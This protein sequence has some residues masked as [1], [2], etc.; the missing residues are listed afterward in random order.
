MRSR[1]MRGAALPLAVATAFVMTGCSKADGGGGDASG[2][3]EGVEAGA[4]MEEY[5]AAFADV[6]PIEL[7]FQVASPNPEAYSALRDQQFAESLEEWSDGKISVNIHYSGAIAA[8]TEVP[9]A[10]VDGRLDLA[11]YYTTYEPQEMP[12]FV[13]MT[14][15]AVQVPST[16]LVGEIVMHAAL[17]EVGFN[18]PEIV[19]EFESRGMYPINLAN[20]NGNISM[21]CNEERNSP[22][23]FRGAQI[24]GNAEA[25]QREIEALGGTATTIELAEGY[26][27][28]QRGIL[29]CSLQS[30][31]TAVAVGWLE[32][33]PHVYFP[34]E[35]SFAAGPGSLV[36][37]SS[38]ETM[39][40]VAQQ[41]MFDLQQE[42]M[43]AELFNG[44]E[45]IRDTAEAAEE[46]G[47]EVNFFDEESEANLAEANESLLED[48]AET[49]STDGEA[50][51][52]A[53]AESIEK[54]TAISEEL[55]YTDDG[56]FVDFTDWFQGSADFEDLSY[57]DA[58]AERMNEEIFLL[59]RPS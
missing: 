54:W 42:Y 47:G 57:Y 21:V 18:T 29:D 3:G 44:L 55:G 33:A 2:G 31:G 1:L 24:R 20:P 30:S 28:F 59:H 27:A 38:W 49:D 9:S 36:A 35:Q 4:T 26:E 16:P 58:I 15:S 50:M 7:D 25:H 22:E 43:A 12:A 37:G 32:V 46:H 14:T 45:S 10:L 34:Q 48:L 23:D 11:H 53:M 5:Q 40:L 8:P 51:N 52:A 56:G 19:E 41:L 39:P 6:D 13:D 17:L